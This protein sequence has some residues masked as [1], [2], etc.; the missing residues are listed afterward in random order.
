MDKT[1]LKGLAVLETVASM[2]GDVQTIDELASQMGLTR[3]NAHRTLQTLIHAGYVE[4]DKGRSGFH[5]T[6][7]L[8]ELGAR[9]VRKLDIRKVA[10]PFMERLSK[11]THETLHLSVLIDLEVV[12]IEKIDGVLPIRAYTSLGGRAPAYAVATGKALLAAA[13]DEYLSRFG[14]EFVGYTPATITDLS[15]LK[16]ELR[17]V[18]ANGYAVNRGEWRDGVGGVAAPVFDG[19][20]KA[21]AALGISGPLERQTAAAIKEFGPLIARVALQLSKALGYTRDYGGSLM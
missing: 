14:N 21:V 3:S 16:R 17:K 1:L 11:V 8:F 10:L 9:S 5:S 12:Y 19:S 7:K 6:M 18:M 13:D 20:N 4:R 2:R 15:V